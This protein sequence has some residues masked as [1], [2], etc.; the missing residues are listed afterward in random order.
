MIGSGRGETAIT[1]ISSGGC[2]GGVVRPNVRPVSPEPSKTMRFHVLY[3]FI[4]SHNF[5]IG[6]PAVA[7]IGAPPVP[8]R[9]TRLST[10]PAP[11]GYMF[12]D[13]T[14]I[15]SEAIEVTQYDTTYLY[16]I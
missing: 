4:S 2:A 8:S 1:P 11:F 10:M 9:R 13:K 16:T 5:Q 12:Y 7:G 15:D 6:A 3:Y 14:E